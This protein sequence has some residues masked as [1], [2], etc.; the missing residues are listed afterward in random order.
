MQSIPNIPV[1]QDPRCILGAQIWPFYF[2][3]TL[4]PAEIAVERIIHQTEVAAT[5]PTYIVALA[6]ALAALDG[7]T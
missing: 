5:T 4:S 1:P 2:T 3:S 7:A 6:G